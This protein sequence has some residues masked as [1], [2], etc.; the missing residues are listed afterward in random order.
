MS[1]L[2]TYKFNNGEIEFLV[3]ADYIKSRNFINENFV[4]AKVIADAT[5]FRGRTC[6]K[7]RDL[8]KEQQDNYGLYF[9]IPLTY[10]SKNNIPAKG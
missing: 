3:R 9:E 4:K 6:E 1:E 10:S 2:Q 8:S 5:R 7:L